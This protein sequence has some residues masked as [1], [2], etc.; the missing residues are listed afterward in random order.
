MTTSDIPR[1]KWVQ[2]RAVS[3][4]RRLVAGLSPQRPGSVHVGF[5][6]DKVALGQVVFPPEYFGF[7][8]HSTGAPLHGKVEKT[9]SSSSS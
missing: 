7:I 3:W 8:F 1:Y 4:L 6:V 2:L 9:S 5:V